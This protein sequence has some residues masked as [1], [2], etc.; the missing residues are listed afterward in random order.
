VLKILTKLHICY[1]IQTYITLNTDYGAA[2]TVQLPQQLG[3]G[4]DHSA[5]KSQQGKKLLLFSSNILTG[6]GAHQDS[7]KCVPGV[8]S[9]GLKRLG[10]VA[11]HLPPSSAKDKN[12]W[13]YTST[14]HTCFQGVY[15]NFTFLK[16]MGGGGGA[17]S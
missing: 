17:Y 12:E 13:S 15:S 4:L 2:R 6:H 11:D 1:Y 9:P 7:V 14:P 5:S 16:V 3:N 8:L 10:H